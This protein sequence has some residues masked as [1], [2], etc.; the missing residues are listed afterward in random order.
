MNERRSLQLLA[1]K[2]SLINLKEI[3]L[4]KDPDENLFTKAITILKSLY[5]QDYLTEIIRELGD[6]Q[7]VSIIDGCK[8]I[9]DCFNAYKT[10]R[11][12]RPDTPYQLF[13]RMAGK[14]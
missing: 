7:V 2:Y 10:L 12:I 11:V 1:E 8:T 6:D 9:Q 4:A 14:G 13:V 3:A 5:T